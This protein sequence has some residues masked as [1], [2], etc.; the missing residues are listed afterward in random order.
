MINK[1]FRLLLVLIFALLVSCT[2]R[3]EAKIPLDSIDIS[4]LVERFDQALFGIDP[5]NI[6]SEVEAINRQYGDFFEV[7][8]EG[9][10]G[11]GTPE[12]P[13]F[14]DY[15]YSFITDNMV[16]ETYGEVQRVFTNTSWLDREMTNAFK[17]YR[18][19]FPNKQI[20][21]VY[22]FISGFNNSVV[23]ADSVLAVSFD[24]YLGRDCEYYPRLGI[25]K[26]LQYN[27]HPQ[28]VPSDLVRA[29]AFSEF[30]FNDSIDN[31]VNNMIYEGSLMY[32][33]KRLLPDQPDSLIFGF[34]PEQMKWCRNNESHM[35]AYLVEHKLLFT[36]DNFTITQFV[37]GAP[38]T[39]GFP[40]ESPGKAAVWLGYRI[41]SRFMDRNRDYSLEMLMNETDYQSIL[42]RARYNP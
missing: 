29:W 21:R 15:L 28:K 35:W 11:I 9:I 37:S 18:Y 26:Y 22:G 6:N 40:P 34:T 36:T 5:E 2:S 16:A 25:A 31:L 20:P 14:E 7:F 33:T 12:T 3:R 8:T 13:G 24:R 30:V 38:F 23:V 42:N 27:M 1:R 4:I 32:L 39:K 10:I 19:Y 41:V 17:R